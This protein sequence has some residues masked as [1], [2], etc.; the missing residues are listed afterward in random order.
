M[1]KFEITIDEDLDVTFIAALVE[2]SIGDI[3]RLSAQLYAGRMTKHAI[4]D[5]TRGGLA[6]LSLADLKRIAADKPEGL[7]KRQGGV[8][9][10]VSDS[11]VERLF[12]KL[13]PSWPRSTRIARRSITFAA[14]WMMPSNGCISTSARTSA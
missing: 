14:P 5:I 7:A 6:G 9:I 10:L 2:I 13:L 4:F 1:D 3:R 12:M 11:A 8:T